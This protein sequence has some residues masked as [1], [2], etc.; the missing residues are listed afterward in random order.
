MP[1]VRANGIDIRYELLGE[2]LPP[3]SR[4]GPVYPLV[5]THGFAGPMDCWVE[6]V[7]PL[8]GE[9]PVLMYDVRGHGQTTVPSATSDY[10]LP[11]FAADLAGLLEAVGIPRAHIGGVSMGGM[12][13]AQF[14]VDYPQFCESVLLCDT[15]CGN[16]AGG[17]AAAEWEKRVAT[18][19]GLLQASVRERGIKETLL[20]EWEWKQEND[21]HLSE[22]PYTLEGDLDR[23]QLM[24]PEGYI[25]AA[26]AIIDRPDLI[27]RLTS[28]RASVLVM[29]GE[30]DDFLP[31]A[32]RDHELIPGSRLVIRKRCAHGSRWRLDTFLQEV[33]S[34]LDDVEA[35]RPVAGQREV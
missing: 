24:T 5:L 34:F 32:L 16:A 35:A 8:A 10:S 2:D 27:G 6:E 33:E 15:T 22:S 20:R 7:L 31:C 30:W 13:T 11:T 9:R 14:A 19:M 23:I 12:I 18:G 3:G 29:V 21:P 17:G 28:I 25:G 26:Q 4:E 1:I